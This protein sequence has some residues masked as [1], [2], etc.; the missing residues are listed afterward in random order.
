MTNLAI[1]VLVEIK[2]INKDV[3]PFFRLYI[4]GVLEVKKFS[5]FVIVLVCKM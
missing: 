1:Q 4:F 3:I 5:L 2:F